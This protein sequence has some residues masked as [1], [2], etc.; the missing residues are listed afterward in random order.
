M[1]R[2]E[3]AQQF[4]TAVIERAPLSE[5]LERVGFGEADAAKNMGEEIA[6]LAFAI[7]DAMISKA[8]ESK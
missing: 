3:I 5:L 6:S 4:L 8:G 1:N 7:A 2:T